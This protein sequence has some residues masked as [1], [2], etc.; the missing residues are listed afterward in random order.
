VLQAIRITI[1]TQTAAITT[2][3]LTLDRMNIRDFQMD[4]RTKTT[5]P[6][7]DIWHSLQSSQSILSR[8]RAKRPQRLFK[9]PSRF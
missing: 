7:V 2:L 6:F 1:I 8:S 5:A 3:T 4:L 9:A